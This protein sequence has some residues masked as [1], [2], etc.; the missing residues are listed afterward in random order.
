MAIRI[1]YNLFTQNKDN[2]LT[3]FKKWAAMVEPC[4]DDNNLHHNGAGKSIV[5]LTRMTISYSANWILTNRKNA[6]F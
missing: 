4:S 2:K 5:T 3:D 6:L 1:V